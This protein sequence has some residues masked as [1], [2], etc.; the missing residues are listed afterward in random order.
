MKGVSTR[1]AVHFR[2]TLPSFILCMHLTNLLVLFFASPLFLLKHSGSLCPFPLQKSQ[3]P[4]KLGQ[5]LVEAVVLVFW[6]PVFAKPY[7]FEWD[8]L[9]LLEIQLLELQPSLDEHFCLLDCCISVFP[10]RVCVGFG[11]VI[12]RRKWFRQTQGLYPQML[13]WLTFPVPC[14]GARRFL[15]CDRTLVGFFTRRRL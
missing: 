7:L 14:R 13:V 5:S 2:V 9:R 1:S 6:R 3:C 10:W 4:L 15:Y 8:C 11:Y 12:S